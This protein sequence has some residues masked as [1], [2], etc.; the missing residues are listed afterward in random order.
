MSV[1]LEY[2]RVQGLS[3]IALNRHCEIWWNR[4]TCD[5]DLSDLYPLDC[6]CTIAM[7]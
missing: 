1:G 7:E 4:M 6:T 5:R 2:R 3:P